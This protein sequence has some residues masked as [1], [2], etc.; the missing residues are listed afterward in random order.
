MQAA[1][2]SKL[3]QHCSMGSIERLK[4]LRRINLSRLM[5]SHGQAQINKLTDIALAELY[6]MSR[7]T[8]SNK[9]NVSDARA[10]Q[11]EDALGLGR[12]W[13]DVDHGGVAHADDPPP[14]ISD[15]QLKSVWPFKTLSRKLWDQLREEK[16]AEIERLALLM[17]KD[18]KFTD[19]GLTKKKRSKSIKRDKDRSGDPLQRKSS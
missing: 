3:L 15:V 10:R 6:Q 11:I 1:R 12:G 16:K 5:D 19:E 14:S 9:R 4:Q 18:A 13:M 17:I 8:G 7:A 2:C